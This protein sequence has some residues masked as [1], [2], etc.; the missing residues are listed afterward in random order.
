MRSGAPAGRLEPSHFLAPTTSHGD[1][2]GG[3]GPCACVRDHSARRARCRPAFTAA[4]AR[5]RRAASSPE[6][7]RLRLWAATRRERGAA[8]CVHHATGVYRLKW[9][10]PGHRR[11]RP[12][13]GDAAERARVPPRGLRGQRALAA[14][15]A[16]ANL[17]L[18]ALPAA[19]RAARERHAA[20]A[21]PRL[22]LCKCS[23]P[24]VCS[25]RKTTEAVVRLKTGCCWLHAGGA[26]PALVATALSERGAVRRCVGAS[27]CSQPAAG[28]TWAPSRLPPCARLQLRCP[29]SRCAGR[30]G[31]RGEGARSAQHRRGRPKPRARV[32]KSGARVLC[33]PPPCAAPLRARAGPGGAAQ[34]RG[35]CAS[36][37]AAGQ[38]LRTTYVRADGVLLQQARRWRWLLLRHCFRA[39]SC[40]RHGCA[41]TGGRWTDCGP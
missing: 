27:G 20:G 8:R 39:T 1:R 9:C 14:E 4:R 36:R 28:A 35:T 29:H 38:R 6:A 40:T 13:V 34:L 41:C 23:L 7:A 16:R 2:A 30:C 26:A 33:A 15:D 5:A 21:A 10:A 19:S 18:R 17:R 37:G 32:H 12:R 22:S 25:L 11:C 24:S 31:A 3:S